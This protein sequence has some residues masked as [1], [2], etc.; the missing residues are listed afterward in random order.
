M[1]AV[2]TTEWACVL[3]GHH[4]Q[5][6][7]TSRATSLHPIL[8]YAWTFFHRSYLDDL[9]CHSCGQLFIGISV[10]TL[11]QLTHHVWCRVVWRNIKSPRFHLYSP[12]LV[13]WN[14]WLSAKLNCLWKGRDFGP[15]MRFR[16]IQLGSWWW[17]GE[18]C[19]VPR[20]LLWRRLKCYCPTYN[21]SYIFHLLQ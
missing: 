16:K 2:D 18:L 5:N 4:S 13:L 17:L 21:V 19:E 6:D 9:E 12:D 7:W 1:G 8:H 20:C 3:C 15:S 11:C 14:F 10:T